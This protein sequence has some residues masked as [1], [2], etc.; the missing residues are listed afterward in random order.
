MKN[1]FLKLFLTSA[2]SIFI[3][4]SFSARADIIE[5]KIKKLFIPITTSFNGNSVNINGATDIEGNIVFIVSSKKEVHTLTQ[6][7]K[8]DGI[9]VTKKIAKVDNIPD[10]YAILTT[11]PINID[12]Y[13]DFRYT[14]GA[15]NAKYNIV[16]NKTSNSDEYVWR[17]LVKAKIDNGKYIYNP[18][19]V[20]RRGRYLFDVSLDLPSNIENGYYDFRAFVETE[21]GLVG[22]YNELVLIERDGFTKF[23][24]ASAI[25][26]SVLYAIIVI[27]ISLLIGYGVSFVGKRR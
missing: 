15:F 23:V 22:F 12:A 7:V 11:A 8:T 26:Y 21:N 5:F 16:Y 9:W 10:F 4:M 3:F 13:K 25:N 17:K 1:W 24:Y 27:F 6:K 14:V 2:V 20:K 18:N 19:A